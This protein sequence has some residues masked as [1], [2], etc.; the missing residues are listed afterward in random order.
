MIYKYN[1]L[2][3]SSKSFVL[4]G[5]WKERLRP[6]GF[7]NEK[8]LAAPEARELG[9]GRWPLFTAGARDRA[10]GPWLRPGWGQRVVGGS[11]G[12]LPAF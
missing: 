12:S 10:G 4:L 1:W 3:I 2:I 7:I 5:Y 6:Q 8:E 11:M 9:L